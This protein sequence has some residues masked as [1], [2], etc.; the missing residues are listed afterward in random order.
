LKRSKRKVPEILSDNGHSWFATS[1]SLNVLGLP[2]LGAFGHVELYR[3]PFLQAA[4][5]AG[6]NGGEMHKDI[7]TVLTADEAI[8]FAVVKPL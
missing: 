7:F 5:A 1:D 3:L 2:A 4:K 8:A 6:L